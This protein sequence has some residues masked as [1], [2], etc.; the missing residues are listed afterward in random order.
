MVD[1]PH[2]LVLVAHPDLEGT[3]EV[4]RSSLSH[5]DG[6]WVEVDEPAVEAE[7]SSV[8]YDQE[9]IWVRHPDI[10]GPP[11][12]VPRSA[13]AQMDGKWVE[14]ADPDTVGETVTEELQKSVLKAEAKA[15]GLPT[16]GTKAELAE[17]IKAKDEQGD[18]DTQ[19]A[20]QATAEEK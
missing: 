5:M 2:E 11:A 17:A 12:E 4:S 20:E 13:L 7:P 14:V 8:A 10:D 9:L 16:S 18:Q 1:H 3:A 19:P 6:Q 15:R